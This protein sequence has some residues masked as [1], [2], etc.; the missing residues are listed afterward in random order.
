MYFLVR[1]ERGDR[2]SWYFCFSFLLRSF[3]SFRL[4]GT[5]MFISKDVCVYLWTIRNC[6]L[7]ICRWIFIS[8]SFADWFGVFIYLYNIGV[9]FFT[10]QKGH[11]FCVNFRSCHRIV[12]LPKYFLRGQFCLKYRNNIS[13]FRSAGTNSIAQW[14]EMHKTIS[15]WAK[16]VFVH[17]HRDRERSDVN[18][19]H[20]EYDRLDACRG[21]YRTHDVNSINYHGI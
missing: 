11:H 18:G 3:V 17:G 14:A 7:L 8:F 10:R 20:T 12:M 15:E 16:I 2:K 1:T 4:L 9:V 19:P 21:I 13:G 5:Y 6:V